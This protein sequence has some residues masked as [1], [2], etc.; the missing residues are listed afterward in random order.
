LESRQ[1]EELYLL[2]YDAVLSIRSQPTFWRSILP[3]FSGAKKQETS[4]KKVATRVVH[5]W[6]P[7]V[8]R[9]KNRKELQDN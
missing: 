2:G 7:W 4:M 1:P 9:G 3:P 5:L 8:Y 6:K